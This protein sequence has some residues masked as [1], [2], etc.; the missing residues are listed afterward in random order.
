MVCCFG[1]LM[2]KQN[3]FKHDLI[4]STVVF[5]VAIPLCLGIALAS[6]APLFSGILSGVIGGIIVGSLSRSNVSVSGPAAGLVAVVVAAIHDLGSFQ[7]FLLA[8]T[9]AG[10]LQIGIGKLKAGFIVDYVPGNVIQGLLC[11]IGIL[12]IIK[13][14]PF[15]FGYFAKSQTILNELQDAQQ[16]HFNLSTIR[17]LSNC[18]SPGAIVICALSILLLFSWQKVSSAKLKMI[19]GPVLVVAFGIMANL[20]FQKFIPLLHLSNR[21]YLVTIPA[22]ERLID[23]KHLFSYP[24]WSAL[25]QPKVYFYGMLLALI[26]TIETLLNLEAAE[27]IDS[28][29][30]YC[31]RNQEMIAQG[32]GNTIAGLIGGL[33]VTSVIVRSSVNVQSG[34][35]TKLSTIMHGMWLLLSVLLIPN[36]INTIPL[37]SLAAILIFVG[38]KLANISIFK[39]MYS[40]G[41]ESFIPFIV[42][43]VM[44]VSTDLLLGVVCGLAVSAIFVMKYNSRL[45]F[46][47][48]LEVYPN[49]DVL[50]IMLPQQATF[51]NKAALIT[52][53]RDIPNETNVLLDASRTLYMDYD[54]QEV[55]HDFTNNLSHEKNISLRTKGF[56]PH[57]S[58]ELPE[59]FTTITTTY[60]FERLLPSDVL[61]IMKEGN[62]RFI[63]NKLLNRDIS[64]HLERTASSQKPLS[65]VLSCVDG[66]VPVEIIFDAAVGDLFVTR[67]IGN[68][69]NDDVISSLEYAC[70]ISGAKL[71]VVMGHTQCGAI[72]T[73][74]EKTNAHLSDKLE[75]MIN[76]I[77]QRA[78][79]LVNDKAK[80]I[81]A[82]TQENVDSAKMH[83]LRNSQVLT[84]LYESKKVDIVG[85]I[86][87]VKTGKVNFD[88]A[89]IEQSYIK[90]QKKHSKHT[91]ETA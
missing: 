56:K 35:K 55:I 12:I 72:T 24:D 20:L 16:S 90:A 45:N 67:V 1:D 18:V 3:L 26:A 59:D 85:A 11:A 47:K 8:L 61:R 32:I 54:I 79:Q 73:A 19:P 65:V 41:I 89:D 80:L 17:E 83:I 30:R 91:K 88:S 81:K 39:S 22:I 43:T 49:G 63:K 6:N 15:A 53:L 70:D 57:Y 5:L 48:Q 76:I 87:D 25:A 10:V 27:K 42:T 40:R 74:C 37:A 33:P 36:V 4:A 9:F 23:I 31:D 21:D 60:T 75:D 34:S 71:I 7:Y 62:K 69:V 66:R 64:L 50:R 2:N 46:D 51:L 52:A 82:L 44:I 13:Q 58:Q 68:V 29:K 78:P 84:K 14:I 77:H 28:Q 38:L 86:Y